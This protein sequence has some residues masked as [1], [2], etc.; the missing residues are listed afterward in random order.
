MPRRG[1]IVLAAGVFDLIHYGHL[2]FLEEA[3]R[4]GGRGA[5][6]V[7]VVARD[8]TVEERKGAKPVMPEEQRRILVEALKPVDEAV[9]GFEEFNIREVLR[10][11]RPSVVAVGYDQDDI[12]EEVKR[13]IGEEGLGIR[14]VR[15]GRFGDEE[16]G[17]STGIKRK[18]IEEWGR[19]LK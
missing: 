12:Y 18:V 8:K 6:L 14:I 19:P 2:K 10:I 17:S 9:L 3:K 7:V 1:R 11:I 13:L 15:I 16:L 4:A 5:R